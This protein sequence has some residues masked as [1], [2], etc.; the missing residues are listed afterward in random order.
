MLEL[1]GPN[2]APG[3]TSCLVPRSVSMMRYAWRGGGGEGSCEQRHPQT[4]CYNVGVGRTMMLC[5]ARAT[6]RWLS[7][8]VMPMFTSS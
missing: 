1:G 8:N 2:D 6:L 7:M 4:P 3:R 5:V